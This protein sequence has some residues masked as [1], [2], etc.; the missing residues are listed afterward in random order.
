LIDGYSYAR[1]QR[2]MSTSAMAE[3]NGYKK[4]S[5]I[6]TIAMSSSTVPEELMKVLSIRSKP[7]LVC[8]EDMRSRIAQIRS[9]VESF[10]STGVRKMAPVGGHRQ[11]HGGKGPFASNRSAPV[12]THHGESN[13]WARHGGN[14]GGN[15]NG[16]GRPKFTFGSNASPP[17]AP[18]V[19]I[20]PPALAPAP[21]SAPSAPSA[22]APPLSLIAKPVAQ[23]KP[24][25]RF[26]AL[27]DD[28][29]E[30]P[31][32][33]TGYH[34]FKSKFKKE[35]NTENELDD[36]ILGHIRAKINK[37]SAQNYKKIL[38]FLRQNMDS[39][40]KVFLEQFM[41]LI[42]SKAAEEDTFVALYAQLLADLVPEFPYLKDEMDKLFAC[43][44][45]CFT[46]A[47]GREDTAATEYSKFLD[48]TKRKTHR[49][50]YSLF[51]A[52]TATRGLISEKELLQTT[53]A[54]T[55]SL[56]ANAS[57]GEQKLLVEELADCLTNI[58]RVAKKPLS[59]FKELDIM[60]KDLK[61]LSSK[62]PADLPGLTF[63]A[64]FAL[65]DCLG[66]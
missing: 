4:M 26:D 18:F 13:Y 49:R 6:T 14:A 38:N 5:V 62:A 43:Y 50:G 15:S 55:R 52:E 45:D 12:I 37:F 47:T 34:K 21:P 64:R 51:I 30:S 27:N 59:A 28:A 46:D 29:E 42:F 41:A 60:F 8:P 66:V 19:T 24:I 39:D 40:E 35:A 3:K 23:S 57:D 61:T 10:R 20:V 31:P 44:L 65:M 25:N 58:L 7:G 1:I 11:D 53:L 32:V 16:S 17:V 36:R 33:A 2:K 9:R 22:P 56:I 54:V 63:K 48:A